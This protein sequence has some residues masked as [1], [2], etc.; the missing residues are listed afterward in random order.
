MKVAFLFPGQGAERPG[1]GLALAER[2]QAAAALL[3]RAAQVLDTDVRR[4]LARGGPLLA[5]TSFLQ[6]VLTA[7]GLGVAGELAAAGIRPAVVAGHSLGEVGAWSAA[8]C[9]DPL[10]AVTVAAIRGRLMERAAREHPGGMRAI[11]VAD[12]AGLFDALACG[13][14]HGTCVVAARNAADQWVLSGDQAAM[15]AVAANFRSTALPVQGPWHSP[16]MAGVTDE[17]RAALHA[18]PR[19][20]GTASFIANRDGAVVT[21]QG[22][23]PDLLAEQL[24]HPVAWWQTMRTLDGLGITHAVVMAP[25]RVLHGLLRRHFGER[26][27]LLGTEDDRELRSTLEV[28]EP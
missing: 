24:T 5:R 1:M 12:E 14:V 6:P 3:D 15:R 10:D 22:L 4:T 11:L 28:L 25:G 9:V 26:I 20:P 16:A 2:S 8:G 23:I 13:R 17:L 19:R 7:V 21:D 18:L 27:R